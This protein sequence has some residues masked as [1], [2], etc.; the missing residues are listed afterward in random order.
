M[1]NS[2]KLLVCSVF[3]TTTVLAQSVISVVDKM[4]LNSD[5]KVFIEK[6]LPAI[7]DIHEK[8]QKT[9][10]KAE[11]IIDMSKPSEAQSQWL[12]KQLCKY[13][14]NTNEALLQ[15]LKPFPQSITLA[16]ASIESGWGS[17]RFF[18]EGNNIFGVHAFDSSVPR[19]KAEDT[20]HGHT[21]WVRKYATLD[22][23]IAGYYYFLATKRAFK[24]FRKLKM[25]SRQNP[26]KISTG[27]FRYSALGDK[28]S[29]MINEAIKYHRFNLADSR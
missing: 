17:S 3:L 28:Y 19:M 24:E 2:L 27:L 11:V 13:D 15:A 10:E 1:K 22:G 7:N 18:R 23:S 12:S 8:Y 26:F 9:Y 16:Q 25:K 14:A 6:L 4:K 29:E 5:Q 20:N 21:V